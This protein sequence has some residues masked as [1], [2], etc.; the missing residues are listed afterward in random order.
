MRLQYETASFTQ[1]ASNNKHMKSTAFRRLS[2]FRHS[3]ISVASQQT[4]AAVIAFGWHTNV[5]HLHTH[6]RTLAL[7]RSHRRKYDDFRLVCIL[8]MQSIDDTFIYIFSC[9]QRHIVNRTPI[10]ISICIFTLCYYCF[11]LYA[12]PLCCRYD[13]PIL[14]KNVQQH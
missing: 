11:W 10:H 6:T 7:S 8:Q 14:H 4:A 9:T 12:Y 3:L 1:N 13:K 5:K 2:H